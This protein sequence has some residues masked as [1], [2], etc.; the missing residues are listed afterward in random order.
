MLE[1]EKL[2]IMHDAVEALNRPTET[3]LDV[4]EVSLLNYTT[5]NQIKHIL[6]YCR[7]L[8]TALT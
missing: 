5:N 2:N 7:R 3:P 1:L 6:T 8:K 4:T